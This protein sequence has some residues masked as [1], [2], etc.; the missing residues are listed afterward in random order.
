MVGDEEGSREVQLLQ[1][2]SQNPQKI[3]VPPPRFYF[4]DRWRG[5]RQYVAGAI[6]VATNWQC[7]GRYL[8]ANGRVRMPYSVPDRPQSMAYDILVLEVQH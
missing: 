6:P 4:V 8:P 1:G 7:L 2:G 5:H 3:L